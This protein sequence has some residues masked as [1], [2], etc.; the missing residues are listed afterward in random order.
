MRKSFIIFLLLFVVAILY[1]DSSTNSTFQIEQPAF[2]TDNM[3]LIDS[4]QSEIS[5]ND[6]LPIDTSDEVKD[7]NEKYKSLISIGEYHL[8]MKQ[9]STAAN[10]FE[11]ADELAKELKDKEKTAD[12]NY[13]LGKCHW[14]IGNFKTALNHYEI[15]LNICINIGDR[16]FIAK[17]YN[18]IGSIHYRLGNYDKAIESLL[19]ALRIKEEIGDDKF[20]AS[21][22]NNLGNMFL[23]LK[24]TS[25]AMLYYKKALEIYETMQNKAK[26]AKA[27]N[28]IGNVYVQE[29]LH[30]EALEYYL[31][32]LEI[33]ENLDSPKGLSAVLNNLGNVYQNLEE[34]LK[35]LKYLKR[36]YKMKIKLNDKYGISTTAITIGDLYL[37]QRNYKEAEKYLLTALE[38]SEEI[39]AY[40]NLKDVYLQLTELNKN[41]KKFQEA[42]FYG[43]KYVAL[44]D[45]LLNA[46]KTEKIVEMETKYETEKKEI[47][48]LRLEAESKLKDLLAIRLVIIIVLTIIAVLWIM[49]L[50]I[51]KGKQNKELASE[52]E[53]RKRAQNALNKYKIQL[54]DMVKIKITDLLESEITARTVIESLDV[55]FIL[56]DNQ[57]TILSINEMAAKDF[58]K[59]KNELKNVCLFDILPTEQADYRKERMNEVLLTG[60]AVHYMDVIQNLSFDVA[61]Y[62]IFSPKGL[63]EKVACFNRDI[64]ESKNYEAEIKKNL[65][66]KDFLLSEIHHRV[67]NNMQVISAMLKMQLPE[68]QNERDRELFLESQCRIRAMSIVHELMNS[69]ENT[70][71]IN[72]KKYVQLLYKNINSE[73]SDKTR[74]IRFDILCENLMLDINLAVPCG[75]ILN[76]LITNSI[77]HAF[78]EERKGDVQVGLKLNNGIYSLFIRDN[79]IGFAQ[80]P[81]FDA[82]R[83]KGLYLVHILSLQLHAQ[84]VVNNESG[85]SI[86]LNFNDVKLRSF[87][88]IPDSITGR[89]QL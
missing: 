65:K 56:T 42:Y 6:F 63:I 1:S 84:N 22:L 87:N 26:V 58:Y 88:H 74:F 69:T 46:L 27:L 23:Q 68:F 67:N 37:D 72:F 8:R 55:S 73:Y 41:T 89:K 75:I 21:T 53:D 3:E 52:I 13:F 79:G 32:S 17:L 48:I 71:Q 43:M 44:K 29:L 18:N 7:V 40:T 25:D 11:T 4:T 64:T 70:R 34:D 12:T 38:V 14:N 5:E 16:I 31:N 77:K 30:E 54:E 51:Q 10:Y 85:A 24:Q 47:A 39:H 78:P 80:I 61:L 19:E 33:Y 20:T 45:S 59:D 83:S 60:K 57:G 50:Y 81:K 76:E 2:S 66:E 36:A 82:I 62:P 15:S 86:T 49:R 35:A 28:N 9:Y